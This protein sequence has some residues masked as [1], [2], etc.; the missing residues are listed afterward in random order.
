MA[1]MFQVL[2]RVMGP[3]DT[4]K[5]KCGKCNHQGEWT[6]DQAF[7]LYGPDAAPYDIRRSSKCGRCECKD[8]ISVWI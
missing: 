5:L 8:R 6:R 4:L 7:A 2:H 1:A 3:A